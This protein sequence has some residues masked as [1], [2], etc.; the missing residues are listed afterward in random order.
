MENRL[1]RLEAVQTVLLEIGQRSSTCSDISEFLQAVHAALGR[2]MYAANFYVA[3]SDRDDG[4][5][6]F[7]Y[8]VD[9]FDL[10]PDP[11]VG[12]RLASSEQ[13]PTAWVMLNRQRLV[14]TA[15]EEAAKKGDGSTWGGGTSAEHWM[16]CP[17]LD[18]QHQ[19]LGAIVIQSYDTRHTFHQEDQALFA[20]IANHVSSALQGM[21][22]MDRLER[23][24]QE[25]TALLAHEVAERRRAENLQHALYEIANL[26]A[27][28][29]DAGTLYQRLHEIISELVTAKNF[30]IALYHPDSKDISI[31]YF[32]DEKDAQAPVQRFHYGVGMS[33]Y[34]LA[35][36]QAS[37]LDAAAYARLVASGE[38]DEALG[39]AGMT[40]W[41]GAPMLLGDRAYGVIIVQSYDQSVI[42]SQPDLDILA[43]MAS[44]VA[45]AIARMQADRAIRQAKETLEEQNAA[46]NSAL[47]ALREAQS[48]L[49]R[50]EKLASLGRLVAGVAHE[51][52]T[53]LGICVTATS[54]LVQELKLAREELAAGELNEDGLQQ[55]FDII[56]QTL[57][58]MTTN[59]QR[60]AALVRSFKQ[61]AVDQSSDDIRSFNL[62]NYLAE[63]LLSLQPKLKG[64]PVKVALDC[65][66][67][68]Q[69]D[70]FPGAVSQIVTNM[71]V[72][73][74]VH[75]FAEDTP[76]HIAIAVRLDQG[77]VYLDYSDDGI[78]MDGATLAQLFD[79]FFTTKRG[80]GGSGLGAHILY[81]LVTGP[82]GGSVKADSAPGQGLRYR[83][84]FPQ[85]RRA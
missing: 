17:L 63:V 5:V 23:A 38:M 26:S 28:A 44:H 54:H 32:V 56:D 83:L 59:T 24:V 57:R 14:M 55:F 68:L 82:L 80:S 10:P 42:Y 37:L 48:E 29:S 79:P 13:S 53:P 36:K 84:R 67:D 4:L 33:S 31:P 46:L 27:L 18:Q 64:K 78:G 76:G 8:F 51:I 15:E 72:N 73:S 71:V 74:L 66:A 12:V 47:T 43:F 25:R 62:H 50:Q 49:V 6:R 9:E 75:G 85:S 81:N 39:N 58:I 34:V 61:V 30:L 40:S 69:L 65:P 21:Q 16:G 35:R 60:A 2:I 52:N 11:E 22:S 41:M 77:Q 45:V 19:A 7:P 3:L 1:K 70:S 20:L